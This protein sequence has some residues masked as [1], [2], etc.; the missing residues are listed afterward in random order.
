MTE[1]QLQALMDWVEAI[2]AEKIENAFGR[3]SLHEGIREMSCRDDLYVALGL[4][5]KKQ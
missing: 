5:E 4:R 1:E 3:D 2:I